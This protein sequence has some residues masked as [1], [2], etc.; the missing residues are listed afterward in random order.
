MGKF[1]IVICLFMVF[2]TYLLS[3]VPV[4][5]GDIVFTSNFNLETNRTHW[6]KLNNAEWVKDD[7]SGNTC[8]L[9]KGEGM[10]HASVPLSPFRGMTLLFKCRVKAEKVTKP[11]Q[12]HNGIKYMLHYKSYS[13]DIWKNEGNI[14]GTFDWK[15][16]S[17][18]VTIPND[19]SIGDLYLGIQGSSGKV[20]FDNLSVTV[21]NAP[22]IPLTNSE[23]TNEVSKD[24]GLRGVMS[25]GSFNEKDIKTL[26]LE[27]KANLIR[28]QLTMNQN[29]VN[30]SNTNLE[31]YDRWLNKKLTE[32]DKALIACNKYG[33]KVVIDLHFAPGGRDATGETNMFHEKKYNDHFIT[34][35]Q[36]I[37]QRYRENPTVWGYDLT[38]EP[39]QYKP[40]PE[41]MDY[42]ETQTRAAEEI[43][44]IDQKTSIIIQVNGSDAPNRFGTFTAINM[45]NIIYEVHMYL[46]FTFTHQGVGNS[47][48]NVTY[49]GIIGGKY[50]D[51]NK[52]K[53]ILQPVLDFQ[54]MYH[55]PIYVGEFTAVR[56]APG[57]SQYISD[58]IDIFDEY[59]WNWTYHSFREWTGW[60]VEF[61][62]GRNNT[63][64]AKKALKDT[65]RKSVLL[66][67][68][69][70]NK[71]IT[72]DLQ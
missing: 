36:V 3:A 62:N 28:W 21:E 10:V 19:A 7:V 68:F 46:P 29:E 69:A 32:L 49:P 55:V 57:A 64:N 25:P 9:V 71:C 60:D 4:K 37:A 39:I 35:W 15:D 34:I 66:K 51:K 6:S 2:Q 12:S 50:Y 16:L 42:I 67:G 8:L 27:W 72:Y 48:S 47:T 11:V 26:G 23:K 58:C 5:K 13:N 24:S 41:G 70:K 31:E 22:P 59:G 17:F 30:L 61:E 52:L 1:K 63:E 56:W 54:L 40:S 18:T 45:S 43:R 33:I 14:N 53:E 44:K 20:W 65:D 38:N